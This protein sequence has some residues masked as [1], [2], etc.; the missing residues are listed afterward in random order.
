LFQRG[1]HVPGKS[2]TTLS[3]L[4]LLSKSHLLTRGKYWIAK[5][6]IC[7]ISFPN[8]KS[9]IVFHSNNPGTL[10]AADEFLKMRKTVEVG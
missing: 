6:L 2:R 5:T 9:C 8:R 10:Q 7:T 4:L 1:L 3:F